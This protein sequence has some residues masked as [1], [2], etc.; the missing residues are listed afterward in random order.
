MGHFGRVPIA[1]AWLMV[2]L[3]SLTLCYFGQGALLLDDPARIANP[4]FY[5]APHALLVPLVILATVA[6]VVAAQAVISGAFS[7]TQ[8]AI[9]LGYLPRM[10]ILH[11]SEKVR[12]Q[13]YVPTINWLLYVAVLLLVVGFGS[14]VSLAAAYGIAVTGTMGATTILAYIVTRRVWR[15]PAWQ[16]ALV[17]VPLL[18]IDLAFFA[19]NLLKIH[20]GGWFPLLL[21]TLLYTVMTTWD[22]GRVLITARRTKK[23]GPLREFI[24]CLDDE[25][26]RAPGTA[27]YLNASADTTPLALQHNIVRNH[28]RHEH[29]IILR[30]VTL[31]VPH[32]KRDQC[33]TI[34]DLGHP[35]DKLTLVTASYG[36]RDTPDVPAA[37]RVAATMSPEIGNLEDATYYLSRITIRP[38]HD[39]NMAFWRKHIFAS[40]AR[41]AANPA[42]FYSLPAED[43]V[44]LGSSVDL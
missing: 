21:A 41:N 42:D 27:I 38:V 40:L 15:W 32:V 1:T 3:P 16:S 4:F 14:S 19:A 10:N 31:E 35:S 24:T 29:V 39:G 26:R 25:L 33:V 2:V 23:E 12:G 34:D 7:L 11:T 20:H 13:I 22:R 9:Q 8:Q 5:L 37:L 6:T 28:L 43:V 44:S 18:A 17:V 30:V 36:F